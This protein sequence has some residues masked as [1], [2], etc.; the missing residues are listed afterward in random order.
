MAKVMVYPSSRWH[1]E[2]YVPSPEWCTRDY[3]D[4]PIHKSRVPDFTNGI[5]VDSSLL[6]GN[7][8]MPV[9]KLPA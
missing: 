3:F 6:D 5:E 7:S 4:L 8:C 2:K 9:S 1:D